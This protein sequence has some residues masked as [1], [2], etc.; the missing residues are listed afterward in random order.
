VDQAAA[1][2]ATFPVVL[3]P[4]MGGANNQFSKAKVVRA[5]DRTALEAA[6]RDAVEQI[7]VENVV[8]QELIPGGGESQFSYAALWNNGEPIAEFTARRTRQYP[9]DFGYTSTCVEVVDE[10]QAIETAR[11][12]LKSIGYSGLVEVEFKRDHRNNSLKL[13]DVNPR[14]WSW[15]GLCA[16]AGVDLGAMLW[17]VANDLPAEGSPKPKQGVAWMYLVRDIVGGA[18]LM[19]RG[20]IGMGEYFS[21]LRK[22]RRWATFAFDDPMPGLIDL[23]LTAWRVLTRRVLGW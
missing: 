23:P 1:L 6:Y 15:F 2:K 21:S 22:V 19:R 9:I 8:V 14:P 16:A 20:D 7:G 11:A 3:K 5:D 13:L 4:N 10:P 12:E 17:R 18:K